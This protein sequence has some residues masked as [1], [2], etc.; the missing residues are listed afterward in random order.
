MKRPSYLLFDRNTRA[1]IFG[2]QTNAIQR[3]LDFDY[4]CKREKP[5]VAG[6]VDPGRSGTTKCFYGK[7]EIFVPV[8][9]DI[10]SAV[11]ENADVDVMI[12]FA[13]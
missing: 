4:C 7:K 12:N 13:S 8:Y 6:V 1:I 9:P 3:M 2:M 5:S 11:A 10:A